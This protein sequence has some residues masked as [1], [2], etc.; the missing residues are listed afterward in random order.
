[1][2]LSAGSGDTGRPE[3]DLSTLYD[4]D[5]IA[6]VRELLDA[7]PPTSRI[8]RFVRL[9]AELL[10]T[11]FAQVSILA[12]KQVIP[13]AHG[14][15]ADSE[16]ASPLEESLCSV[17]VASGTTLAVTD[18]PRHPW[19]RDMTPVAK[20]AVR[21][22]LGA[23]LNTPAGWPVGVLCV[24][25]DTTR[26]W[27]PE[28]IELLEALALALS[29]EL[30]EHI[31]A[32]EA[33]H[34]TAGLE[35]SVAAAGMGR[36][37]FD[38]QRN[39]FAW[40]HIALSLL[41]TEPPV[42]LAALSSLVHPADQERL[43]TDFGQALIGKTGLA[44][45]FRLAGGQAPG[46]WLEMRGQLVRDLRSRPAKLVGVL[47]D[48]TEAKMTR[49]RLA[50][51]FET[52]GDAVVGLGSD[53]RFHFLNSAA[54]KLIGATRAQVLQKVVWE[55][56][57]YSRGSVFQEQLELSMASGKPAVFEAPHATSGTWFEVRAW[58]H[59]E[60]MLVHFRDIDAWRASQ[61][62]LARALAEREQALAATAEANRRLA[63]MASASERL[64][65]SLEPADVLE[66][67]GRLVVPAYG[68]AM[69]VAVTGPTATLLGQGQLN[70]NAFVVVHSF[71][72][73]SASI[74]DLEA[75]AAGHV[76]D[77]VVIEKAALV[78]RG[79]QIGVMLVRN[80]PGGIRDREMLADL[81]RRAG[82]ALENAM[83][84]GSERRVAAELQLNLLPKEATT[85]P[86]VDLALRYLPA[87][88]GAL[89]GG[90]FYQTLDVGGKLF[91]SI[92]DVMGHSVSSAAL[93]GQL[94]AVVAT[95]A[96]EGYGPAEML[97]R[98]AKDAERLVGFDFATVLGCI[99]DPV[100]RHLAF[101]SA[102]HPPILV[103]DP[104]GTPTLV[105]T[106][107]GPP[108]GCGSFTY[109]E[110]NLVLAPN[111]TLILYTDGLVE[112]RD[113]PAD[114]GLAQLQALS[115]DPGTPPDRVAERILR[116]MGRLG[117]AGDDVAILVMRHNQESTHD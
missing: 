100:N 2:P 108:L 84:F 32:I 8:A 48:T 110:E 17:T 92:G 86:G 98:L 50:R 29:E 115:L 83:L 62:A 85:L 69:A 53:W 36:F 55:A 78:S 66:S 14:I 74:A 97:S 95:L 94:R 1:M 21:S 19:V 33:T 60:G 5:R 38:L 25:D 65:S 107:P 67:L 41:G 46:P 72:P 90:D 102:G 52:M 113:R 18:A 4:P 106:E 16:E 9:S 91:L 40:D 47:H 109:S 7:G 104:A 27:E 88:E 79:R 23:I 71:P 24:Y 114:L 80:A 96:N 6:A 3:P 70:D 101:A 43:L 12:E 87:G 42:D 31:A 64:S 15:G 89:A 82:A 49:E 68:T 103:L 61:E 73:D 111:S 37:D 26:Q 58:P 30:G 34:A 63:I 44:V 51:V 57:P 28:E 35:L 117:G 20:G 81:A 10:H 105:G 77:G 59:S 99:Y 45:E 75:A 54:E 39:S 22:Y 11:K 13:A 76:R 112:D 116:A 56:L 93:M